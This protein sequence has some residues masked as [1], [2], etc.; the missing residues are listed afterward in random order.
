[1]KLDGMEVH[2]TVRASLSWPRG[3]FD[4][5]RALAYAL[6]IRAAPGEKRA[7]EWDQGQIPAS[8]VYWA[9][10]VETVAKKYG[11]LFAV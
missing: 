3:E 6:K 2:C 5:P 8:D 1:M 9:S 7:D 4:G 10:F 11:A